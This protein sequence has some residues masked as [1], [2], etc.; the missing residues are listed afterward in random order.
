MKTHHCPSLKLWWLIKKILCDKGYHLLFSHDYSG[1][2]LLCC[3]TVCFL[4]EAK[5]VFPGHRFL[6]RPHFMMW[7]ILFVLRFFILH[8]RPCLLHVICLLP[9]VLLMI[10][11]LFGPGFLP[12]LIFFYFNGLIDRLCFLYSHSG[13]V[14]GFFLHIWFVLLLSRPYF[15]PF[16]S[17]P[18]ETRQ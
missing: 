10:P 11:A 4:Q 18:I 16:V 5:D 8:F 3:N 6:I 15:V 17:L 1:L 7:F 2:Q 13:Y 12:H 9:I 14:I